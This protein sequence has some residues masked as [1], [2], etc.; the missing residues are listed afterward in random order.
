MNRI[1]KSVSFNIKK[2]SPM[3]DTQSI[4]FE[5]DK[6]DICWNNS[7]HILE[8]LIEEIEELKE[9][10]TEKNHQNIQ[11]E[12]GDIFFT[13]LNL[14]YFLKLN[15]QDALNSANEKFLKRISAIEEIIGDRI[16]RQSVNDF[17]NL[18]KLAKKK[19]HSSK[20]NK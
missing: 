10:I 9:A 11:E 1:N 3:V 2:T 20:N 4:A 15:H 17:Q 13:L 8:K 18:W 12:F 16:T 5:L 6:I 14:S 19:L 7:D